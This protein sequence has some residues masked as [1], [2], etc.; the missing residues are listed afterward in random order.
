MDAAVMDHQLRF[1]AVAAI[2]KVQYPVRVAEMVMNSPHLFLCGEGAIAFAR[3]R[4]VAEYDPASERAHRRYREVKEFFAGL[5][6]SEDFVAWKGQDLDSFWNLSADVKTTLK[7]LAGPSDTV[8]AV[9]R[10]RNGNCA[11]A[12]ST[13]GTS[14]MMLGRVGDTPVIGTGLY[15][16]PHGAVVAT[17]DGEE[18][19]RRILAKQ[20]YDW[21]ANGM[22]AQAAVE[23]GI[24]LV[25]ETFT[26]GMTAV[27]RFDEG[28][29]D[30]RTM[31]FSV[32][33][34]DS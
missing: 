34:L 2:Q 12:L 24:A 15:A 6:D 17:G 1:G 11:A 3:H 25:S 22:S 26:V 5:N 29:A 27:S 21:I 7:A 18:I 19:M 33:Y 20:V 16:G 14:I 4:G 10:D 28:V 32:K 8:G 23:Q 30:N 31:P 13:G 9:V